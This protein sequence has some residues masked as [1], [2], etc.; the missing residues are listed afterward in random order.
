MFR[1][2]SSSSG[3]SK[4]A[5]EIVAFPSVNKIPK[6]TRNLVY[7]SLCYTFAVLGDSSYV[8]YAAEQHRWLKIQS[9]LRFYR[10]CA[11]Q[12]SGHKWRATGSCSTSAMEHK[13]AHKGPKDT[14]PSKQTHVR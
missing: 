5:V 11:C 13:V 8:S 2:M 10:K 7:A 1:L 12:T 14:V 9:D 4:I 3:V 6:S